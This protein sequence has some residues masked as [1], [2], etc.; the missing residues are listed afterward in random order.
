MGAKL[1]LLL[2]FIFFSCSKS[3]LINLN[4]HTEKR[5][6]SCVSYDDLLDVNSDR[7]DLMAYWDKFVADAKCSMIGNPDYSDTNSSINIF[8][9][10]ETENQ[11]TSGATSEY[12]GY[13]MGICNDSIVNI[14]ILWSYWDNATVIEK[15]ALMY[16]EFGHDVLNLDHGSNPNDIMHPMILGYNEPTYNEFVIAKDRFFKKK[17]DSISYIKCN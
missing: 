6:E 8:F 7:Y 10:Y 5:L 14:G 2:F 16:H 3:D 11:I 13:A 17:Y 15:L 12:W 4:Q 1:S 9:E